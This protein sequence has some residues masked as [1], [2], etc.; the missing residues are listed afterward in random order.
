MGTIVARIT[1]G[2][3]F[4][5]KTISPYLYAA[6]LMGMFT[7]L[8]LGAEYLFVNVLSGVVSEDKT[9]L[10]QNYALGISA[11]GFVLYPLSGRFRKDRLK[12][13]CAVFGCPFCAWVSFA[14]ERLMQAFSRRDLFCFC[15][16]EGLAVPSFMPLCE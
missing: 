11:A 2:A 16:S 10:A 12:A 3:D 14:A 5:K 15:F 7:F 6:A 1:R 4:H 8:F 9:V 13:V